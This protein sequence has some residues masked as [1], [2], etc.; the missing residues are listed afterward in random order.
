[1]RGLYTTIAFLLIAAACADKVQ[2]PDQTGGYASRLN[3][4]ASIVYVPEEGKR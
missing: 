3:T 1:M 4:I 2:T